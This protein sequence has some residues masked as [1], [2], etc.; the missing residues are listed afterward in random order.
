ML[1]TTLKG[2]LAHKSRL[3]LTFVSIML[4]VAFV[5]GTFVFT[6]TIQ[7][8][9]DALFADVYAGVD[10]SVRAEQPEFGAEVTTAPAAIPSSLVDDVR[11]VDG[12][13][14]AEGY[15]QGFGQIIDANGEPVGGQG[16]PTY[17]YSWI[18]ESALNPFRIAEGNGR[19]PTASGELVVDA[20]TAK[21]ASLSL[22]DTVDLQFASG[23]EAFT[24][25]GIA[26][27]GDSDNLAGATISVVTLPDAQRA[28]GVP[29]QVTFIDVAAAEGTEATTLVDRLAAIVPSGAEVVSGD[30]LMAEAIGGFTQGLSFVSI[31]LLAFALV[32]VLVGSFIIY[33]TF[34]IIVVQRTRELALLRAVGASARQV[35]G[36]VLIEALAVALA[37][38]AVGV[39]AGLGFAQLL[40][41]GMEAAGFGPPEG[42]LTVEPRT[43][44]V[45][46]LVGVV[47]T[48]LSALVPALRA[49]RVAPVAAMQTSTSAHAEKPVR[50]WLRVTV[51]AVG[52]AL[53]ALGLVMEQGAGIAAGA[54]VT[55]A[56][57]LLIAPVLARPVASIVGRPI[58]GAVGR[59][60][61]DNAGRDPRRTAATASALTIGIALVVFTAI[62]AAS[63]KDSIAATV[64]ESFPA[65]L[66]VY[67]SNP[68]MGISTE[69]QQAVATYAERVGGIGSPRGTGPRRRNGRRR[70]RIRCHDDRGCLRR[71]VDR[72][73][74]RG[75]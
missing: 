49:A 73:A 56:G 24:L 63:A 57:V 61:R 31:A 44:V 46:M 66:I 27:F 40:K 45:G 33:N 47:V 4:G 51:V 1:R 69:A 14:L 60:A 42:P 29:N 62:F 5:S 23:T 11:A 13:D 12:V 20:A 18:D 17:V 2:T 25:V 58:P 34:R 7:A 72:A 19:A 30:T 6:D 38:S 55:V 74:E 54:A 21:A 10:A 75:R 32:A 53:T 39:A 15:V 26:S 37:A 50:S 71:G 41:V 48:L 68:Y 22:G 16:A 65:D 67:S 3:V 35:V 9:F 70:H 52:V 28:L 8:R 64:E 43:I 59:L 36:V